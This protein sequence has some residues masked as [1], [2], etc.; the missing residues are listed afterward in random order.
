MD[1]AVSSAQSSRTRWTVVRS[2][3]DG[4]DEE[5]LEALEVLLKRHSPALTQFL[6]TRFQI[7]RELA[8]DWTQDFVLDRILQ[9]GLIEKAS[10][11]RGRFRNFLLRSIT[12]FAL[13]QIRAVNTEKRR[14]LWNAGSLNELEEHGF[15]VPDTETER[16]FNEAFTRH[17]IEQ[18]VE[19]TREHCLKIG[20]QDIWE[21]FEARILKPLLHEVPAD[22]YESLCERLQLKSVGDAHNLLVSGK[23][24]FRRELRS[25]VADYSES[26]QVVEE[27]LKL[28]KKFFVPGQD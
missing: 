7:S 12:S 25:T 18:S 9:K 5:R 16:A 22:D 11:E 26:N 2:V 20:R 28:L 13:N 21:V 3:Q 24:M 1:A 6:V 17:A 15:E 8:E 19:R 27:E 10:K 4:T 14:A 23:R